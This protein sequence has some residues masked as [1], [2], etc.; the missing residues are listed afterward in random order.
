MMQEELLMRPRQMKS[1]RTNS[2]KYLQ[3]GIN[4]L[5][6][7]ERYSHTSDIKAKQKLYRTSDIM[8]VKH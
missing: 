3:T 4:L 5:G 1:F 2:E 7:I 8:P 6:D